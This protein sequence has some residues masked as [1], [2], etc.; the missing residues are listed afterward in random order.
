MTSAESRLHHRH[1][2][3]YPMEAAEVSFLSTWSM[4]KYYL[5]QALLVADCHLCFTVMSCLLAT[6]DAGNIKDPHCKAM[7]KKRKD[8]WEQAAKVSER[9]LP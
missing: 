2:V 3:L 4:A 5:H 1:V 6:Y 7:L 8:L 9:Y